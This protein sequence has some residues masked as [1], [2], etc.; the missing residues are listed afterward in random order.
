MVLLL[1]YHGE[2]KTL[3]FFCL[4]NVDRFQLQEI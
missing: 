4:H 2:Q 1:N 3:Y